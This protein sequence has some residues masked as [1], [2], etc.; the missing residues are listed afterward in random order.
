MPELDAASG[1]ITDDDAKHNKTFASLEV[2]AISH[3]RKDHLLAQ[4]VE[5]TFLFFTRHLIDDFKHMLII[6]NVSWKD[7]RYIPQ[8]VA[9]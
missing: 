6:A 2:N 5:F 4:P 1:V 9:R 7:N 3:S 8:T